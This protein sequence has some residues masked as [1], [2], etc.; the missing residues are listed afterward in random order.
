MHH[1]D[2][3]P[4]AVK[5]LTESLAEEVTLIDDL[6]R[7]AQATKGLLRHLGDRVGGANLEVFG[8]ADGRRVA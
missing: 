4:V 6:I 2:D 3:W 8:V 1:L 5:R 7:R